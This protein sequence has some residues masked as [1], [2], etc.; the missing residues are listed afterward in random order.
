MS[1]FDASFAAS[2]SVPYIIRSGASG[3]NP[4]NPKKKSALMPVWAEQVARTSAKIAAG[5]AVSGA[6][7][8]ILAQPSFYFSN[9]MASQGAQK[10]PEGGFIYPT[11]R[12]IAQGAY[13]QNGVRGFFPGLLPV[14]VTSPVGVAGLIAGMT[15]TQEA[16]KHSDRVRP[17]LESLLGPTAAS[18]LANGASGFAGQ[19]VGGLVAFCPSSVVSEAMQRET[20]KRMALELTK[21]PLKPQA[22]KVSVLEVMGIIWR[23]DG[24]LG[25]HN[26]LGAQTLSFGLVHAIAQPT[27]RLSQTELESRGYKGFWWNV[28]AS[29]NAYILATMATYPLN[30][31]KVRGQMSSVD[32]RYE[33]K[34]FLKILQ[35]TYRTE[36][37][38]RGLYQGCVPRNAFMVIRLAFGLP[39]AEKVSEWL[40]A[41]PSA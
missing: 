23:K 36:G 5:G 10:K 29:S 33:G 6:A 1:S 39:A 16:Y 30:L 20:Q 22:V 18:A 41:S 9:V 27:Y 21:N 37:G 2:S 15:A 35:E 3:S 40:Y 14:L 25:F 26:K 19:F 32:A 13:Q 28:L 34:S 8:D 38:I 31:G 4:D 24:V 7:L 17:F 12:K 11:I